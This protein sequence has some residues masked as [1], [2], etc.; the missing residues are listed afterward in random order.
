MITSKAKEVLDKVNTTCDFGDVI[1][2]DI[3]ATDAFGSNAL[4]CVATW[5]DVESAKALVESGIDIN[6]QGEWGSAP[7]HDAV[8]QEHFEMVKYLLSIGVNVHVK[9]D[10]GYTAKDHAKEFCKNM[11]IINLLDKI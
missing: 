9:D 11:E 1:F 5:G 7:L 4:H 8:L 6:K 2:D 3:N 10:S